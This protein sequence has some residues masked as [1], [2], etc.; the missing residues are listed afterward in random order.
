MRVYHCDGPDCDAKC[1]P[2]I[3][4]GWTKVK[5]SHYV[6]CSI[7]TGWI[8]DDTRYYCPECSTKLNGFLDP[9]KPNSEPIDFSDIEPVAKGTFEPQKE[10]EHYDKGYIWE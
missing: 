10:T 9:V 7:H 6:D 1:S 4:S 2:D 3:V 5:W 8:K